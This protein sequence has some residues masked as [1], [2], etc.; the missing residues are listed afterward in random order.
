MTS[1]S[2]DALASAAFRYTLRGM[3]IFPLAWGQKVPVRGSHGCRDGSSDSD[4]A[5]ARW[6]RWPGSNIAASTG[7]RSGFWALDVDAHHDGDMSLAELEAEHGNL[8]LTIMASTPHGGTHR[9]WKWPAAGPEIRNSAG[10]VAVG[11]DVRGEGGSVVLPPSVL[12]DGRRYR[13]VRNG[14]RAFADAPAWLLALAV[15][16]PPAPRPDSKPLNGDVSAYVASAAAAELSELEGAREGTRNA[17]L[18]CV[19]FN[20]GQ[21]V[22]AGA[23]PEAWAR[24]QLETR[25]V[26]I[27]LSTI[28]ARRTIDSALKAAQPREMQR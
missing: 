5:R 8:P 1:R 15:P 13:W 9:Y 3:Q 16:P 28:E 19:A 12:A 10:R 17:V 2:N 22:K 20:L 4:V 7:A 23:L 11:I 14:V 18:N 6:K 21:F 27:G 26:A 25:A 24:E